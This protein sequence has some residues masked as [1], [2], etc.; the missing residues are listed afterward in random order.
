[1]QILPS[2]IAPPPFQVNMPANSSEIE[3]RIADA[4]AAIDAN[5]CL[6][7]PVTARQFDASFPKSRRAE[8]EILINT[9][10]DTGKKKPRV[11]CTLQISRLQHPQISHH[12]QS[13]L[14]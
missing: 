10:R 13:D 8:S 9:G 7:V 11:P 14:P 5:L 6:K 1:M 2:I 12:Q 4:S 3:A